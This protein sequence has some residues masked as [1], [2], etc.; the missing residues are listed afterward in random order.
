MSTAQTNEVEATSSEEGLGQRLRR[1]R[2]ARG[3][4]C[5]EVAAALHLGVNMIEALELNDS[6]KLPGPV[7]VQ[8]YLRKYARL[9]EIPEDSILQAY[10]RRPVPQSNGKTVLTG[11]P[12]KPEIRSNHAVVRMVTWVIVFGLLA[13]LVVWWRG[14][15]QWPS[16]QTMND[17]AQVSQ[18]MNS[19]SSV[20]LDGIEPKTLADELIL[21]Q[22]FTVPTEE[23]PEYGEGEESPAQVEAEMIEEIKSENSTI[24]AE[25]MVSIDIPA[26]EE[27]RSESVDLVT[28]MVLDAAMAPSVTEFSTP[29]QVPAAESVSTVIQEQPPDPID[30]ANNI[31]IEFLGSCWTEIY[32]ASNTFKLIGNMQMGEQYV[33]GGEPPYTFVLG[34]SQGTVL[35]IKGQPFDL[36]P[37]TRG[38]VA[39]FT[40]EQE[41][42]SN[43]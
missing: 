15:L 33:L 22:D 36:A 10:G 14:Y 6:D 31:V 17:S 38:N 18:N 43:F 24:E 4:S 1:A 12:L 19:E 5:H 30:F 21:H 16:G 41:A 23:K 7:F 39:R 9:L 3:L 25:T 37:Y 42:I 32:D 40:L 2:E 13:L 29:D 35:T 26:P 20:V 8:G 34:N 11:S 28:D 27:D